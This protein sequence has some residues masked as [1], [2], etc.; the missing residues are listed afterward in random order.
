MIGFVP[1]E[2]AFYLEL[3]AVENLRFHA[4]LY[5]DDARRD[6]WRIAGVL[7]LVDLADRAKDQVTS[8]L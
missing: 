7:H 1:Q 4:A 5:L 3:S 2:T 6:S 8:S